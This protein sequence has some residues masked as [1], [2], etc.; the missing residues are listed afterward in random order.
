MLTPKQLTR[1]NAKKPFIFDFGVQN[2]PSGKLS[3]WQKNQVFP[4]GIQR[5]FW[6]YDVSEIRGNHA[7]YSEDQVI[8]AVS[9]II[10]VKVI[11]SSGEVES[12]TLDHPWKALYLPPKYWIETRFEKGAV[13]L[14]MCNESFNERDYIRDFEKF[15][16]LT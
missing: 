13:L 6:V 15:K 16:N 8:V 3:F 9:G 1:F 4:N 10:Y 11:S 2:G 14:G 12:Y 7:H 5:C